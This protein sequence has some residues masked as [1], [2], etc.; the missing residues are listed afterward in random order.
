MDYYEAFK[1]MNEAFADLC[2][3]KDAR[4]GVS[5]FLEKRRPVWEQT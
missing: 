2:S 3:T 5:A 4:E 1:Y